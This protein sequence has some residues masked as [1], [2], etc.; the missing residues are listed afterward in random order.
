MLEEPWRYLSRSASSSIPGNADG[1][2]VFTSTTGENGVVT[3][4]GSATDW[5]CTNHHTYL[6]SPQPAA[7]TACSLSDGRVSDCAFHVIGFAI[8]ARR[9]I[10][11]I[12]LIGSAEVEGK[13]TETDL[14][15]LSAVDSDCNLCDVSSYLWSNDLEEWT[16][17]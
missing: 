8:T 12:T 14:P 2:L 6:K 10:C 9:I 15:S 3:L 11:I 13:Q 4:H 7:I 5:N 1:I 16:Y 17:S